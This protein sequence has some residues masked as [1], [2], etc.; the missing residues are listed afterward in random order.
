M[1]Q[2]VVLMSTYNG[3]KYICEQLESLLNQID[4]DLQI[5]IRDDGSSDNTT[6]L[7]RNYTSDVIQLTVGNNLGFAQSFWALLKSAPK[8]E[9]FAFCDQDDLWFKDKLISAIRSIEDL[10]CPALY[11]SDVVMVDSEK[12][13]INRNGFGATEVLSYADSLKRSI[14]PG[15]TFVFNQALWKA[16]VRYSGFMISHDWTTYI[17]ASALGKVVFD[18]VPHM[19][20]RIHSNNT[21]GFE[22]RG[23]AICRKVNRFIHPDRLRTRS[24]VANN[25][26][27]CFSNDMDEQDKELTY[28][29]ANCSK[30][31][32]CAIQ[33]LRYKEYR[34]MDFLFMMICGRI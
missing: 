28:N 7:I 10:S 29:F 31:M 27:N 18:P 14:L 32:K 6:D 24:T 8:A 34:T 1:K 25:I 30:H 11:T 3:E 23:S 4:V 12:R 33:L 15:C 13:I 20:Y 16:L 19:Y 2:V 21:I 5:V 9:Y 17:I 26:Y 22:S